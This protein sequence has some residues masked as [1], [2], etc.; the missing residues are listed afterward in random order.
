MIHEISHHYVVGSC[1]T[2]VCACIL[3]N[4]KE[5]KFQNNKT[6]RVSSFAELSKACTTF[7]AVYLAFLL[8]IWAFYSITCRV[9]QFKV[10][11]HPGSANQERQSHNNIYT[12]FIWHLTNITSPVKPNAWIPSDPFLEITSKG[13]SRVVKNRKN[14]RFWSFTKQS[15]LCLED[16]WV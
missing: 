10:T 1:S 3:R 15:V 6:G 5:Q 13:T 12:A 14:I 7:L 9:T 16:F 4:P 11:F 2:A 8:A